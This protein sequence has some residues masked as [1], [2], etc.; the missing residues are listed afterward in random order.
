[1][2]ALLL[3]QAGPSYTL[4]PANVLIPTPGAG[5]VRLRVRAASINPLDF[6]FA[7]DGA[8]LTMPHILGI[9]A[10]GEIDALGPGCDR[11]AARSARDGTD[12]SVSLGCLCRVRRRRRE[13]LSLLPDEQSF[14]QAAAL[15]CAGLTA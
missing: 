4:V 15:P 1:M 11:M 13:V 10:A 9:D 3:Q 14:E 7:R 6:K 5:E 12:Q 8:G 2:K